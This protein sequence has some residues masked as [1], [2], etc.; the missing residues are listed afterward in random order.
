MTEES[1]ALKDTLFNAEIVL[2]FASAIQTV[3]PEFDID[4]F[5]RSVFDDGWDDLALMDRMRHVA[6]VLHDHLPEDYR[7]ALKILVDAAPHLPQAGFICLVPTDF[8]AQFGL[9][10][11]D[12]SLPALEVFTKLGSAEFAIR[13]FIDKYP[14]RVMAQMLAWADHPHEGVRRTASEGC[15]PR[16]PWGMRLKALMGDP[17]PILPI[18]EKLKHDSSESVRRSVANNLNDISKDNP[19]VV[20][21]LLRRWNADDPDDEPIQAITRH[22]LRTL[23]KAGDKDA[24]ELL[25]FP[26][27]PQIIVRDVQVTPE[28]IALG[29]KVTLTFEIEST[30]SEPQ[31]LMIDYV[32]HHMKANGEQTPKVFKLK[33]V[34][35]QPGEVICVERR[36]GIKPIT[37][38][39]Y[40]PGRHSIQPQVNGVAYERVDFEL[41]G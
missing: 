17:S 16:L 26:A 40:Y 1:F 33:Q 25:G 21:D 41:T 19:A 18:L 3:Y 35:I 39:V 14:D 6:A 15:R 11:P 37:T 9:D 22:A 36:H 38:R 31:D 24:L 7:T 2:P 30:G 32:V 4:S 12:A 29:E 28:A 8:V 23:V 20:I 10:D 5:N 13:P 27:D 34:T